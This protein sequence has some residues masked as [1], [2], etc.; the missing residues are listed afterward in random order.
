[1]GNTGKSF[2]SEYAR[3]YHSVGESAFLEAMLVSCRKCNIIVSNLPESEEDTFV[4][5]CM[6]RGS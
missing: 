3:L 5:A 1:M 2:A 6:Q 4:H